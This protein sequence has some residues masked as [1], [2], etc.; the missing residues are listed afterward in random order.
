MATSDFRD[1]IVWQKSLDLVEEVYNLSK[2]LPKDETYGLINQIR[3]AAVSIPSNVAEGNARQ[4][5]KDYSRFLNIARGSKAE[6]ETQLEICIRINY[7]TRE[8]TE[9]A[10]ELCAE[11]GR[12]L[13]AMIK[14]QK[15][16]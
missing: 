4:A 6:V 9:K 12:M 11:V 7:L 13:Y 2:L 14:N 10:F 1:L 15:D 8:Q 16:F 5:S 3:R